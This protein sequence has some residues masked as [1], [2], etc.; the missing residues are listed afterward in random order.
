MLS[1]PTGWK[2]ASQNHRP[3]CNHSQIALSITWFAEASRCGQMR[4]KRR[5]GMGRCGVKIVIP[6][7]KVATLSHHQNPSTMPLRAY[8][9]MIKEI[10]P[11]PMKNDLIICHLRIALFITWG[12]GMLRIAIRAILLYSLRAVFCINVT[13]PDA[14]AS[15]CFTRSGGRQ[16][17]RR[18]VL[19]REI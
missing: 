3:C 6:S 7:L 8:A 11:T 18:Y 13:I 14:G 9:A 4:Q 10:R 16:Q 1:P 17:R 2:D 19:F 15:A 5:Q 12:T